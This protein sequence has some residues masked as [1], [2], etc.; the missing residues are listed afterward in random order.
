MS[1]RQLKITGLNDLITSSDLW[2]SLDLIIKLSSK[3]NYGS[4]NVVMIPNKHLVM[5]TM[6][7][8]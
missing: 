4:K 6:F 5:H 8:K 7:F 3:K 1:P 2:L